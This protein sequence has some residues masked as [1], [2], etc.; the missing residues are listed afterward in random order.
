VRPRNIALWYVITFVTLGIGGI[1]WYYKINADAKRLAQ[2]KGWSPALSVFAV[3]VG[4][5]VLVPALISM[6]RTWTRVREATHANGLS[7]G[8]QFCLVFIPIVNIAYYGVLQSKLNRAAE[9]RAII[10]I[11]HLSRG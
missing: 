4:S 10:A 11:P 2:N 3:T 1:V 8:L 6:W 7:A 9:S 5:L